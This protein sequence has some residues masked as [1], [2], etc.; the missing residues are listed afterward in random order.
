MKTIVEHLSQAD[1]YALADYLNS[2][3]ACPLG[4]CRP[5]RNTNKEPFIA[6]NVETTIPA[7]RRHRVI[8]LAF[9]AGRGV[10]TA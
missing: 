6:W 1:A 10:V 7:H 3:C 8:A 2:T 4:H 5:V 9:L